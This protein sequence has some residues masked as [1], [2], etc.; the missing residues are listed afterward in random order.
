MFGRSPDQKRK[1]SSLYGYPKDLTQ[2]M[3]RLRQLKDNATALPA[4]PDLE[5][6]GSFEYVELDTETGSELEVATKL[7]ALTSNLSNDEGTLINKAALALAISRMKAIVV[8]RK[9]S[10]SYSEK[11]DRAIALFSSALPKVPFD[12]LGAQADSRGGL[13]AYIDGRKIASAATPAAYLS[14]PKDDVE[15]IQE[16]LKNKGYYSGAIDGALGAGTS[17]GLTA[18]FG[19]DAWKT[20]GVDQAARFVRG[21]K[22]KASTS[23]GGS[24]TP[25]S[26]PI[27]VPKTFG[28]SSNKGL[29]IGL[30]AAGAVAVGLFAYAKSRGRRTTVTYKPA[31]ALSGL[32]GLEGRVTE[33]DKSEF[34]AYLRACTD[35][36]VHGVYDK[37][38]AAHRRAYTQLAV[39][40]AARRGISL[41]GRA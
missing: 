20:M 17:A 5:G 8:S 3:E 39:E 19:G 21:A 40:E 10:V 38:K 11:Y 7:K 14:W 33:R 36:Q 37:E 23:G 9:A 15:T 18:I 12:Y 16:D 2:D 24:R 32:G 22:A 27:I 6:F 30:V 34:R 29:I 41:D 31:R 35:R 13:I 1:T 28:A 4:A 26:P 25:A